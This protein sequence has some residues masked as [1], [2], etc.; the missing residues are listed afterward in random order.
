MSHR[1]LF[2]RIEE[3]ERQDP[4]TEPARQVRVSGSCDDRTGLSG[5]GRCSRLVRY[6]ALAR[7]GSR[8]DIDGLGGLHRLGGFLDRE[9]QHAL[10][11]MSVDGALFRLER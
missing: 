10:V 11:E 7:R 9:M 4:E 3:S 5:L 6:R 2:G 1:R 8:L